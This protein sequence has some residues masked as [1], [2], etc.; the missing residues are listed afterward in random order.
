MACKECQCSTSAPSYGQSTSGGPGLPQELVQIPRRCCSSATEWVSPHRPDKVLAG[1]KGLPTV[2]LWWV[3]GPWLPMY[4]ECCCNHKGKMKFVL[5]WFSYR[6]EKQH[7]SCS[8]QQME[9]DLFASP[10]HCRR[11]AVLFPLPIGLTGSWAL[12]PPDSREAAS[13]ELPMTPLQKMTD[14]MPSTKH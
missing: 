1:K 5:S 2:P 11:R 13:V 12:G 7:W 8:L 3:C 4:G 6:E 10:H 9:R 14:W